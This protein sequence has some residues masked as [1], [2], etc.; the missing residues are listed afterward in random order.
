M[1]LVLIAAVAGSTLL[2][3]QPLVPK[4]E[5]AFA[6]DRAALTA[7]QRKRHFDELGPQ[8]RSLRK[9]VHELPNGYEFQFPSDSATILLVAE[10]TAGEYVCCPFFDIDLHLEREGGAFWLRLTGR[11]GVKQFIRADFAKWMNT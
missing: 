1:S 9:T 4:R 5:S 7:E 10:W 3:P 11:D 2:S 8:L 6:C